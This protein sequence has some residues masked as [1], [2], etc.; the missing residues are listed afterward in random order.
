MGAGIRAIGTTFLI[1][2]RLTLV[3]IGTSQT[4]ASGTPP[5]PFAISLVGDDLPPPGEDAV[6]EG[7]L[8]KS[9]LHVA[10]WHR[11]ET[12]PS[13]WDTPSLNGTDLA[14]ANDIVD[15]VP[16]EWPIIGIGV[17]PTAN[18]QYAVVVELERSDGEVRDWVEEH[19]PEVVWVIP[20]T[21]EVAA[22]AGTSLS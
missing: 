3:P 6:V 1:D 17:S 4:D 10:A 7:D 16:D 11:A 15:Q 8:V 14:A 18:G 21:E 2:N 13:P 12:A 22:A 20:F 9:S 19:G 5:Y